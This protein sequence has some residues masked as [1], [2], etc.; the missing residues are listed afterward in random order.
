MDKKYSFFL[1]ALFFMVLAFRLFFAFQTPFFTDGEAYTTLREVEH[2]KEG[3]LPLIKDELS[4]GGIEYLILPIFH[5][6]LAF[7]SLFMPTTIACKIIPNIMASALVF[8]MYFYVRN[9]VKNKNIAIL[10]SFIASFTPIYIFETVNSISKFS[11]IAPLFVTLM[12]L[13]QRINFTKKALPFIAILIMYILTDFSVIILILSILLYL[14]LSWTEGLKITRREI[15]LILFSVFITG[16]TYIIYLKDILLEEGVNTIYGNIPK[17]E[18]IQ[19]FSEINFIF[20]IISIGVLPLLSLIIVSLLYFSKK[21]KKTV[22]LP[23]SVGFMVA[24]LLFIKIIPLTVGLILLG[25]MAVILF[26]EFLFLVL[27]YFEK[28][29]FSKYWWVIYIILI[30]LLLITSIV[31]SFLNA[32]SAIESTPK[33]EFVSAL[34]KLKNISPEDDVVVSTPE[35]GSQVAYFSE[36]RNIMDTN[37]LHGKNTMA[38]YNDLETIYSSAL[39]TRAIKLME[40]YDVKYIVFDES[41]KEKYN[42]NRIAYTN[43]KCFPLIIDKNSTKIYG[44]NCTMVR[45]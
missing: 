2:I 9:M 37:Y 44:L 14:L 23:M 25:I 33:K 35:K 19:H 1:I 27:N 39:A 17:P 28:T 12:Y 29:K 36:K 10:T 32:Q 16:L 40:K 24:F 21:K 42:I 13:F 8:P 38:R 31:P 4:Y 6:I 11:I 18:I 34:E 41:A 45:R 20:A 3:G 15:E 22:Y 5:Y 26:G 7:F 43:D 30:F